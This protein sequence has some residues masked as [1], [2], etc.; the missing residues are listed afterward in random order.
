MSN[1]SKKEGFFGSIFSGIA[2]DVKKSVEDNIKS[3]IAGMATDAVSSVENGT[4]NVA[5]SISDNVKKG[6]LKAIY[7]E[8]D[9]IPADLKHKASTRPGIQSYSSDSNYYDYTSSYYSAKSSYRSYESP[10]KENVTDVKI[11][12]FATKEDALHM[13]SDI[14]EKI[15]NS[16]INACRIGDLYEM[17]PRKIPVTSMM[18]WKYG[19]NHSD[20]S[21]LV[22]DDNTMHLTSGKYKGCWIMVLPKAHPVA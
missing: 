5:D 3:S 15:D 2:K 21:A 9:K 12:P 18:Q 17:A 4:R 19:W 8:E 16:S 13:I 20:I 22:S 14:V 1:D 11:I 6:I 10:S 7:K